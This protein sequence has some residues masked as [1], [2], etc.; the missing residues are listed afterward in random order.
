MD[1]LGIIL[2]N[3]HLC[4]LIH[5]RIK[6]EGG[7]VKQF[8]PS[9]FLNDRSKVMLLLWILYVVVSTVLPCL[10]LAALW[11]P[12]GRGLTSWLTSMWCFLVR[13]SLTS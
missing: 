7:T 11:P 4:V 10:F 6:G 1:K 9:I 8:K 5:I 12:V 3:K 2:A 13:L